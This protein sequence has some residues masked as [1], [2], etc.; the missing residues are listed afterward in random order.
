MRGKKD[1]LPERGD[2]RMETNNKPPGK[3]RSFSFYLFFSMIVLIL[4]VVGFLTLN[5]YLYTR[6][7]YDREQHLLQVQTE[8]NIQGAMRLKDATWNIFDDS[9]NE[10]MNTSMTAVMQEYIRSGRDPAAMDL[11]AVRA[12]LGSDYDIYVIDENGVIIE[13]TYGPE[14]GTDF[15][16]I[17]YFYDYLTKIR[18]LSGFFPDRVVHELKGTGKFRKFAYMP[19]PDHKYI[20]ELGLAGQY[21]DEVNLELDDRGTIDQ[22]VSVNPY[23]EKFRIFNSMGR[24]LE[25]NRLPEES[26]QNYLSRVI[27]NR[28]DLE[29]PDPAGGRTTR[30]IFVD[31]KNV[32]YGSDPSRTVEIKY[33][34]RRIT[35]SLNRLILFHLLVA[36]CAIILGCLV[37]FLISRRIT[38]PIQEIVDDADQIARGDLEHRIRPTKNSE[39]A[40]LGTSINSMV[41]T[42]K[43][44]SRKMKDDEIFQK[45]MITQL[46]VGVFIK[47]AGD[48]RYVF[49]NT[50]CE[51]L[52]HLPASEVI[53]KADR[54]LFPADMVVTIEKEDHEFTLSRGELRNKI[55]SNKYLGNQIVHMIIVPI[56]DSAGTL[57]FI[58]GIADDV[59]HEN[60]NLKM[61]LLFSI[62]RHDILENLSVIMNH[63][64]R[65]QL[66]NNPEEMQA[67]F[68]K[69]IESI[70]SI[71][72]Q[73]S[74][75]R[76]LQDMGLISPKWQ[77]IS[78]VFNDAAALIPDTAVEIHDDTGDIEIYADPLLPRVFYTL[79][80]TSFRSGGQHLTRITLSAFVENRLLHIVYAD[81]GIGVPAADKEMIFEAG[82]ESPLLRGLFLIRELLS[83]T[84]ITITENGE[85]GHGARFEIIVPAD[86]FRFVK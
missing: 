8:Q 86:K 4:C 59:S 22:I 11:A 78:Y 31:M 15:K 69:T 75:M 47:R 14:V 17:P 55:L 32:K 80:E 64:E 7:N 45:E 60:V 74:S 83:F 50:A 5:D 81:D 26:V 40:I 30:Y 29:V 62:T 28:S 10:R 1:L 13:T 57:I 82:Y 2:Q 84:R 63:L 85:P 27:S 35:D 44:A 52:F 33:N 68:E 9:L 48:G 3:V 23:V 72:N 51:K 37:A 36:A 41:D 38:R 71:R 39:F 16:T 53:G 67:F 58:L 73:I 19:T 65:A 6:Q 79:L 46:P 24:S 20:L 18:N 77:R 42:L 70:Q 56:F 12:Q 34:T 66:M 61:D 43:S 25:D 21:F 49:W 54:E 76:E